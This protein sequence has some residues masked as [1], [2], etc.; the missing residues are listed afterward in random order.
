MAPNGSFSVGQNSFKFGTDDLHQVQNA[1]LTKNSGWAHFWL[2]NGS[3][4]L[5]YCSVG[6]NSFKF[7]TDDLYQV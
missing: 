3:E 5:F 4:W 2:L 6:Q 7:G 1:Y